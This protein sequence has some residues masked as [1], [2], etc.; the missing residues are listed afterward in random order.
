MHVWSRTLPSRATAGK[1]TGVA[2]QRPLNLTRWLSTS[3][4]RA[5]QMRLSET[6]VS[7]GG[8]RKARSMSPY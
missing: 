5:S 1:I 4:P 7:P 8:R 2:Q 6:Q 3:T